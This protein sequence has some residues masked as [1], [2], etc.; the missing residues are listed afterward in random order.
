MCGRYVRKSDKQKIAEAFKL[1]KLPPNFTLPPDYNVAPRT[2][3]PVI[4][5][6][7]ATGEREVTLM[8]WGLIP[9]FSHDLNNPL[10]NARGETVATNFYFRDAFRK[11][12]CL[13]PADLFYEWQI[14]GAANA[15]RTS[16]NTQPWAIGRRDGEPFGI[17]GI[18]ETWVDEDSRKPLN[19]FTIITTNPNELM[20]PLHDR[21]P[22]ILP[23]A[24]YDRWL[25]PSDAAR[26]P[27]DLLRP[28]A[29]EEMKAFKVGKEVGNVRNIGPELCQEWDGPAT[30]F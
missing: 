1:D 27:V 8:L 9:S 21:M 16:K 11:R 14:L 7:P 12:R 30:L 6:N 29:A 17:A 23:K 26:P 13:V 19:T 22:V 28:H 2:L 18:W 25:E 10:V 24:D 4:Y 20:V 15:K 5:K 3:Q